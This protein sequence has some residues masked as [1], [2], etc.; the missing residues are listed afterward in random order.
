MA[1]KP[2]PA[3]FRYEAIKSGPWA[4]PWRDEEKIKQENLVKLKVD[5]DE[6]QQKTD[7]IALLVAGRQ[8]G[9]ARPLARS[10]YGN[11][12]PIEVHL[13]GRI[14]YMSEWQS[15]VVVDSYPEL[16]SGPGG[17]FNLL[18]YLNDIQM[19][20]G[21]G[22]RV[23]IDGIASKSAPR[24]ATVIGFNPAN[25]K[26]LMRY[27]T[28]DYPVEFVDEQ[29][30]K[31]SY[32]PALG[33]EVFEYHPQCESHEVSAVFRYNPGQEIMFYD[34]TYDVQEDAEE[35]QMKQQDKYMSYTSF[36]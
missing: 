7:D 10:E 22:A 1:P 16:P 5:S 27:D 26:Y 21:P 14:L 30:G 8:I 35:E 31:K 4:P 17:Q 23:R 9:F 24:L 19:C 2:L 3:A 15:P 13:F 20:Y 18:L 34:M 25:D 29:T 6:S 33:D 28:V 32:E 36:H 12:V 11:K